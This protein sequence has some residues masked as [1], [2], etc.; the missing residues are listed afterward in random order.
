MDAGYDVGY[1]V[2]DRYDVPNIIEMLNK[3]GD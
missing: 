3:C 1:H 2:G